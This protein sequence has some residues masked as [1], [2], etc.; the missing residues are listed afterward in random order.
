[1]DD[2]AHVLRRLADEHR[3]E[4]TLRSTRPDLAM[5]PVDAGEP[6]PV[7]EPEPAPE[8]EPEPE[9]T[10][11]RLVEQPSTP[12]GRRSRRLLALSAALVVVLL[13]IGG[14]FVYRQLVA[15]P[16][17]SPPASAGVQHKGSGQDKQQ[18]G[19]GSDSSDAQDNTDQQ[20]SGG[21]GS[22]SEETDKEQMVRDYY[23]SA[24]GGTDE[25]WAMLG[26]SMQRIGRGRY[27]AFWR[28]IES[29]DVRSAEATPDG[30]SV[31]VTLVYHT[32]DGG[33]STERKVERLVE[34]DDGSYLIDSDQP[35][36]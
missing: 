12:R 10:R 19:S 7:P 33:T 25:A 31:Q 24:P 21:A 6:V 9:R 35:A 11:A 3:P 26:P 32:S 18:G 14:V 34:S 16:Q 23:A 22:G 28:T 1:M 8:P 4:N 36:G 13:C 29:V 15:E 20:S 30:D 2:A 27:D 17:S 5:A